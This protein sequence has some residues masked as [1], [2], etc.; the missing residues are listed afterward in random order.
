MV[1]KAERQKINKLIKKLKGKRRPQ[2]KKTGQKQ[3]QRQSVVQNVRISA[4][5]QSQRAI[6]FPTQVIQTPSTDTEFL[7]SIIQQQNQNNLTRNYQ[8]NAPQQVVRLNDQI[9]L[10]DQVAFPQPPPPSI[11]PTIP[12]PQGM[13]NPNF[14][15]AML[16]QQDIM[17]AKANA[18]APKSKRVKVSKD[19]AFATA[20][21]I[22]DDVKKVPKEQEKYK[23]SSIDE[24]ATLYTTGTQIQKNRA[25]KEGK[26]RGY[27][28]DEIDK[29]SGLGKAKP[30]PS[31]LTTPTNP[32][33]AKFREMKKATPPINK[34]KEFI[35]PKKIKRLVIEDNK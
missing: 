10:R 28:Q 3:K 25:L 15:E 30:V 16:Q 27:T 31:G 2:K 35:A 19:V 5:Q 22:V 33:V 34:N 18:N 26:R 21:P 14:R 23:K 12:E 17:V 7:R 13:S 20:V 6:G 11:E 32:N 8:A 4:P 1:S 24:L 29:F 9:G